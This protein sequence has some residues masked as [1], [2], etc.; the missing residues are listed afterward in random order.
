MRLRLCRPSVLAAELNGS[1]SAYRP[2]IKGAADVRP[3]RLTDAGIVIGS[4]DQSRVGT[5]QFLVLLVSAVA[6]SAWALFPSTVERG[7]YVPLPEASTPSAADVNSAREGV[8][9]NP[10]ELSRANAFRLM[11]AKLVSSTPTMYGSVT[12]RYSSPVVNVSLVPLRSK[13]QALLMLLY[14]QS[15][16]VDPAALEAKLQALLKLPD[17]VLAQL[18]E[19][20]DLADLNKMLDAVFL[21]TSDLSG[22]KTELDKIDVTSVPGPSEQIDVI[23]VNGTP[24]LIV[25][26]PAVQN[27]TENAAGSPVSA[28]PPPG[29]PVTVTMLSQVE[30][31]AGLTAST[32][33]V[34]PTSAQLVRLRRRWPCRRLLSRWRRPAN[35]WLRLRRQLA[36]SCLLSRWRR[37]AN[38]S[39]LL[40]LGRLRRCLPLRLSRRL[41]N[42]GRSRPAP[43]RR[44]STTSTRAPLTVAAPPTRAAAPLTVAAPPTRAAAP[45]TVAAPPTRAAAPPTVAAPPTRAATLATPMM[46]Q[47]RTPTK[48]RSKLSQPGDVRFT[49]NRASARG[50]A[51]VVSCLSLLSQQLQRHRDAQQLHRVMDGGC[52]VALKSP[53]QGLRIEKQTL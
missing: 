8:A 1:F 6:I 13:L 34:A 20:P 4:G 26:S 52:L 30:A 42:H 24:A 40:H 18:M 25:H 31:P 17:S 7:I 46:E 47:R 12:V 41:R 38:N 5:F 28:P 43:R 29:G 14:S 10:L 16:D 39:L 15:G 11:D 27:G 23:K 45:L 44:P 9:G 3:Y 19:H 48:A 2:R 37:A 49:G 21:G 53:L 36:R 33:A 32:F 51:R 35:N 22:V 50:R